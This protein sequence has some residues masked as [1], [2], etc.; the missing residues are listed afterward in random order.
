MKKTAL[1][2]DLVFVDLETT[3]FDPDTHEILEIAAIRTT[4]DAST[5]VGSFECLVL[6]EHIQSASPEALVI[7]GYSEGEWAFDGVS[8]D[9]A[10][11]KFLNICFGGVTLVAHSATF[12]W[13]FLRAALTRK[14]L[15]P[16]WIITSFAPHLWLGRL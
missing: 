14:S 2:R 10:L 4:P 13:G 16:I 8:L 12:D 7:N 6:P 9:L 5:V 11:D 1:E 3:G 15:W